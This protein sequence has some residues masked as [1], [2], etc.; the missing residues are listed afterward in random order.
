[1]HRLV[2]PLQLD[3]P[4]GARDEEATLRP[5]A[6]R[7]DQDLAAPGQVAQARG[8]I[9]GITDQLNA[10]AD[11]VTIVDEHQPGVDAAVKRQIWLARIGRAGPDIGHAFMQL[12][13]G[14]DRAPAIVLAP[15]RV[16]KDG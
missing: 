2:A 16:A 13:R 1:M 8:H 10:A 15:L 12:E 11:Q 14:L 6:A 4:V 7:A 5:Q 3:G 9:G